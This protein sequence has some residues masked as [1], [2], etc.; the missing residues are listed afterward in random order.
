MFGENEIK[1]RNNS[2]NGDTAVLTYDSATG[3]TYGLEFGYLFGRG[4]QHLGVS[5][6]YSVASV[7]AKKSSYIVKGVEQGV[8]GKDTFDINFFALSIFYRG[9]FGPHS[10]QIGPLF[11]A[12]DMSGVD[13]PTPT[14][15]SNP[16]DLVATGEDEAGEIALGG[17]IRYGYRFNRH[18]VLD[19]SVGTF[20][21]Q[22][23]KR[24]RGFYE[25]EKQFSID[26]YVNVGASY[27]F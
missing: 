2:G 19:L 8:S 4:N 6:R 23:M 5:G 27:R 7:D 14:G 13:V 17:E 15:V 20:K 25:S 3:L 1:M 16:D 9:D 22:P 11:G 26:L 18:F 24:T 12:I 21:S 10:F